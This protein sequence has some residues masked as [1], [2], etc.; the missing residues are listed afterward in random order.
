MASQ[1]TGSSRASGRGGRV[2]LGVGG[3]PVVHGKDK[4]E[5]KKAEKISRGEDKIK[6][7]QTHKDD[8]W[9]QLKVNRP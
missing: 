8:R 3:S 1:G 6:K 2:S 7:N 4:A 9:S 5:K